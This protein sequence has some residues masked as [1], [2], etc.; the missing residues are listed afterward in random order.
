VTRPTDED[1]EKAAEAWSTYNQSGK[2]VKNEP[3]KLMFH[4]GVEWA[5]SFC[6]ARIKELE[7]ERNQWQQ[8]AN[9]WKDHFCDAEIERDEANKKLRQFNGL[10]WKRPEEGFS[11]QEGMIVVLRAYLDREKRLVVIGDFCASGADSGCGCCSDGIGTR[12]VLAYAMLVDVEKV[13]I[14][15]WVK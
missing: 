12:D 15:E 1:I 13:E 2:I 8:A 6:E 4:R 3:L 7:A 9:N 10:D 11:F 14:P 5:L